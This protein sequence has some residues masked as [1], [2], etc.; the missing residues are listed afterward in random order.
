[1]LSEA[2]GEFIT[3]HGAKWHEDR[4]KHLDEIDSYNIRIRSLSESRDE[5]DNDN[6]DGGTEYEFD[7]EVEFG[8][9]D[10]PPED[11]RIDDVAVAGAVPVA[12]AASTSFSRGRAS[13]KER[14]SLREE[15]I[16][17]SGLAPNTPSQIMKKIK[18]R[19]ASQMKTTIEKAD[20]KALERT[21]SLESTETTEST[22]STEE[23][24]C[25]CKIMCST[26]P[27]SYQT[28]Q[29]NNP[30]FTVEQ[31]SALNPLDKGDYAGLELYDIKE[32]DPEFY[33]MLS[34]DPFGTRFPGGESYQDLVHRLESPLIDMEQQMVPVLVVSHV[35][36]IQCL[37]SYF[38][39]EPVEKSTGIEVPL[40]T[41]IQMSPA[42]GG[43]W[44][45]ERFQLLERKRTLSDHVIS[46]DE[47]PI[48]GDG[49]G[50]QLQQ[51]KNQK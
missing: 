23:V 47:L 5:R 19:R 16:L 33:S 51:K 32:R 14:R 48:W 9:A 37:V 40:E 35:S 43:G 21:D 29:F 49:L 22:E 45:E 7:L 4:Q 17:D 34:A 12:V 36:V 50:Q 10:P 26:M 38:R 46:E 13:S 2:L 15:V 6:T 25:P 41:V 24:V 11:G 44:I 3:K 30:N 27:R 8:V 1:M 31:F 18:A 28:A 20:E 42:D 39:N